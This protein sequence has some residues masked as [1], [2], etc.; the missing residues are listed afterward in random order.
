MSLVY[1]HSL[2]PVTIFCLNSLQI[3]YVANIWTI[4]RPWLDYDFQK[5]YKT[6]LPLLNPWGTRPPTDLSTI[7]SA[8]ICELSLPNWWITPNVYSENDF[9]YLPFKNEIHENWTRKKK[10]FSPP[11]EKKLKMYLLWKS[12]TG[13]KRK[14]AH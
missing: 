12:S 10:S 8:V 9:F 1:T 14:T 2:Y 5:S 7:A 3:K 13:G 11:W 6:W 4:H